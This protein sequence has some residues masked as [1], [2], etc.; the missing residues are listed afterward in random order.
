MAMRSIRPTSRSATRASSAARRPARRFAS[1]CIS[2]EGNIGAGKSTLLRLLGERGMKVVEEPVNRWQDAGSGSANLLQ[3]FYDDPN[4][5][6][7]TFQTFAFL[8]RA[9]TAVATMRTPPGRGRDSEGA[10]VL[11]RSLLSDKWCFA[12]NCRLTGLFNEVRPSVRP[13]VRP[14]LPRSFP[15]SLPPSRPTSP[16]RTSLARARGMCRVTPFVHPSL[17]SSS[18]GPT[19]GLGAARRNGRCTRTTTRG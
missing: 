17:P 2:L 10:F 8:S 19:T 14:S 12:L 16:G 7:F 18:R 6:A 1:R 15:P 5:W 11:E 4:R 9:Q 13:C 3:M